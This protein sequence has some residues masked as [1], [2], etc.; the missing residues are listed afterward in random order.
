MGGRL[1]QR[2]LSPGEGRGSRFPGELWVEWKGPRCPLSTRSSWG[3]RCLTGLQ[4]P[5][6]TLSP[7]R[8]DPGRAGASSWPGRQPLCPALSQAGL[9]CRAVGCGENE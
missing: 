3:P 5:Q 6:G 2:K 9:G 8:E 7:W 4:L 1:G